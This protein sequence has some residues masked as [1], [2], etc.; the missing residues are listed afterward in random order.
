MSHGPY[1][2]FSGTI[3]SGNTSSR[4]IDL[5]RAWKTCYFELGTIASANTYAIFAAASASGTYRQVKLPITPAT[6]PL[7]VYSTTAKQGFQMIPSGLRYLKISVTTAVT[8]GLGFI[9]LC[10]DYV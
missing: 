6:L 5:G 9:V 1:V 7:A 4:P 3:E 8:D 10:G 2:V